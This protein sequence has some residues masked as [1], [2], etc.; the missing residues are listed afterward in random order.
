MTRS[1]A[2]TRTEILDH[3]FLHQ[4]DCA[5]EPSS[6]VGSHHIVVPGL[7]APLQYFF[8]RVDPHRE[9]GPLNYVVV[10]D[11][12]PALPPEIVASL[13][14]FVLEFIGSTLLLAA[15]RGTG[16]ASVR[17]ERQDH[18]EQVA[19]AVATVMAGASWD[20]SDPIVVEVNEHA[21]AVRLVFET[22]AWASTISALPG[23]GGRGL[24]LADHEAT[25]S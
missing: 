23:E 3:G 6:N 8:V 4:P 7:V 2:K 17:C 13:T 21:L 14:A 5:P 18:H 20:E 1:T 16:H 15:C 11:P 12:A 25:S 9:D 19:S 22:G 24:W 10:F